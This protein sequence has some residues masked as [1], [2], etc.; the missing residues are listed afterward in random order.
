M[1]TGPITFDTILFD[2][3]GNMT[4]GFV[5]DAKTALVF[6]VFIGCVLMGADKLFEAIGTKIN[7]HT[8]SAAFQ[9]ASSYAA[10]RDSSSEGSLNYDYYNALYRNQ[11]NKSVSL[12]VKTG[13]AVAGPEEDTPFVFMDGSSP[14]DFS[15]SRESDWESSSL[16]GEGYVGFAV[17][18]SF[19][20]DDRSDW[21]AVQ[22]TDITGLSIESSDGGSSGL[23]DWTAVQDADITDLRLE[24]PEDRLHHV[25][26]NFSDFSDA[27]VL[28]AIDGLDGQTADHS[29]WMTF[30]YS[31]ITG[32]EM[33]E[34]STASRLRSDFTAFREDGDA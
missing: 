17:D 21:T 6:A 3:A 23:S 5:T 12:S 32:L 9:S 31:D 8:A 1:P 33:E 14:D 34:S 19:E 20:P 15:E 13:S 2:V 29:E 27:D 10:L 18:D 26:D 4:L 7:N 28:S 16:G 30:Q 22:E 25:L 24:T 11:L